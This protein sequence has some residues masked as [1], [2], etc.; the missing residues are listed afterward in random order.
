MSPQSN[1]PQGNVPDKSPTVLLLID[2]INPLDFEG[3]EPLIEPSVQ[4][5]R[6]IALLKKRARA[7]GVPSIYVNDNFGRWRSDFR[8]LV[9]YC[10]DHDTPGKP[11]V[12]LLAPEPDDYFVLKP[13]HSA[14]H[15]T[16]LH[17]LLQFLG[18]RT[19]ILT[20]L[21]VDNCILLSA[22][23][24][25][26]L[27]YDLVVVEDCVV[28]ISPERKKHAMM[29]LKQTLGATISSASDFDFSSVADD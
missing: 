10:T 5:S 16:P 14:F 27:E 13:K 2:V 11:V 4:A 23:D 28:A 12:E 3:A 26:M 19:L 17:V 20:G 18:A 7:A 15:C 1:D 8:S 22:G 25:H 29:I 9:D 21:T 24:A 6:R